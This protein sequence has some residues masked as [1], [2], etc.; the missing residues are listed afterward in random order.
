MN[1]GEGVVKVLSF[2]DPS[3]CSGLF[4]VVHEELKFQ[5]IPVPRP[6]TKVVAGTVV[7]PAEQVGQV[8]WNN[9]LVDLRSR[10]PTGSG[11]DVSRHHGQLEV[12]M[13]QGKVVVTHQR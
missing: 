10:H 13:R 6:A 7:Y 4:E 8:V 2:G 1:T 11:S 3:F 9:E 12:G 5:V